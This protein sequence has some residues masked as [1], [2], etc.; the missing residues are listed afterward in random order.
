MLYRQSDDHRSKDVSEIPSTRHGH[1]DQIETE[2]ISMADDVAERVAAVT[3]AMLDADIELA[4]A[5]IAAD[6]DM[7]L[8]SLRVEEQCVEVL[9]SGRLDDTDLRFVM[10]ALFINGH[11]ERSAALASN[12]AKAVGRLQGAR[13]ADQV[14]DLIARMSVQA[15]TL[16]RRASESLSARDASLAASIVELDDVLDDL[17][18]TYIQTVIQDARRGSLDAQQSM[19]LALVGR[20]FERIGDHAGN[21]G[22]RVRFMVDGLLP[23]SEAV[24]RDRIGVPS[25]PSVQVGARGMAVIDSIAEERRVD[26]I[27]RDFVANVSHELKTPIAAMSILAEALSAADDDDDRDRLAELL[28]RES[29]RVEHVI[30]DLLELTRLEDAPTAV[31]SVSMSDVVGRSADATA[32]FAKANRVTIDVGPIPD[33]LHVPGDRR[34]LVRALTNLLDNA[35]RYSDEN[36][37]VVVSVDT[38]ETSVSVSVRDNGVG[39]PRVDLERVFERFY[40]VDRARSRETGGTGLGLSIVRHVAQLHGGRI[41]VE[42]KPGEGSTFTLELPRDPE[43][44]V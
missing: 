41:L 36:A 10:S 28:H 15:Q 35:V 26:A 39:I 40:R 29:S 31:L 19:Q 42:S 37:K 12:I 34:Q 22:E 30:D 11:V 14:R 43:V 44:T 2:L 7:D 17:H 20:F 16:F 9:V 25:D 27:R 1:L 4:D 3:S 6:D 32:A 5:I 23:G 24:A 38:F 33:D 18:S 21:I 8:R 13:P